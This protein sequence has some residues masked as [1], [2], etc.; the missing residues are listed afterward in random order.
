MET[1]DMM[2]AILEAINKSNNIM[3]DFQDKVDSNHQAVNDKFKIIQAEN[4]ASREKLLTRIND[5]SR[6]SSRAS[7]RLSSSKQL[8]LGHAV[9]LTATIP[10]VTVP[11]IVTVLKTPPLCFAVPD[12]EIITTHMEPILSV[13]NIT[14]LESPQQPLET[15]IEVP[16][17]TTTAPYDI[18][19][20]FK[21]NHA[22][23]E[24]PTDDSPSIDADDFNDQH[25][26]STHQPEQPC[27]TFNSDNSNCTSTQ[28]PSD[29][30]RRIGIDVSY[31]SEQDDLNDFNNQHTNSTLQLEHPYPIIIAGNFINNKY[32]CC[33]GDCNAT[34]YNDWGTAHVPMAMVLVS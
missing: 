23:E 27:F 14:V 32:G 13:T 22:S 4:A 15:M 1:P 29:N 3:Q 8:A 33:S 5:R 16:V 31:E 10:V 12:N 19:P 6:L 34:S 17:R 7:S 26:N 28:V 30:S 25:V 2:T 11:I 18:T 24:V 21:P 20:S 9:T